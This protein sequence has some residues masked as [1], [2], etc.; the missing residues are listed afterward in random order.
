MKKSFMLFAA[1][2]LAAFSSNAQV[3][4]GDVVNLTENML[5]D[6]IAV[7]ENTAYVTVY[8]NPDAMPAD[9]LEIK[10]SY[11]VNG[12]D[13]H[14]A[15]IKQSG[16]RG[17]E[18]L[19]SVKVCSLITTI[20]GFAFAD[21]KKLRTFT[22]ATPG[23]I[24]LVGNYAFYKTYALNEINLPK[25]RTVV[26]YAFNQSGV[27]KVSMPEVQYIYAGGFYE[28]KSL[29]EFIG[30]EKLR[31]VGGVAFCNAGPMTQIT[32][33]PNLTKIGNTAFAYLPALK[34]I[35]IPE[36]VESVGIDA[37]RGLGLERVFI[38]CSNFMDFCD[39]SCLLRDKSLKEI[40]CKEGLSV[41]IKNYIETGS[42]Q[43]EPQFLASDAII[44]PL[45]DI[46]EIKETS[47]PDYFT[48]IDKIDDIS[49]IT[50]FDP[51]TG[52]SIPNMGPGYHITDNTVGIRYFVD[53][54]N[55]LQYTTNVERP[56]GIETVE[57]TSSYENESPV[58]YDLN[59]RE[60]KNPTNGIFI[61]KT[62]G[63]TSK[64]VL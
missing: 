40:Y 53:K 9:A 51:A 7:V 50:L 24:E 43:H 6:V 21:C 41:D 45:S 46:V 49:F 29:S 2:T 27:K 32:L 64:V 42:E 54:K 62:N 1:A 20:P 59:G 10:D 25:C 60:V 33:G 39:T 61:I 55:L 47:T 22:E 23:S 16:F 17:C 52:N 15:A 44:K 28:C 63:K 19:T 14:P 26:D 5:G 3:K 18:E 57:T 35:V 58:Y 12:Y 31:E 8:A 30:G 4:E 11:S 48:A 34:E 56:S 38:L 36:N 37:F 13:C